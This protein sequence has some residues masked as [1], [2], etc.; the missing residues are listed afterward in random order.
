MPD[1]TNNQQMQRAEVLETELRRQLLGNHDWWSEYR[2]WLDA[3]GIPAA[4][5]GW[6]SELAYDPLNISNIVRYQLMV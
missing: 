4:V 3:E 5:G 1:E 2:K 6:P